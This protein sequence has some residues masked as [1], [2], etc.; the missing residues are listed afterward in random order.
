MESVLLVICPPAGSKH[1]PYG[2]IAFL[3]TAVVIAGKIPKIVP[4]IHNIGV[5]RTN[6]DVA[7]FSPSYII[8]VG[9]GNTCERRT[10]GQRDGP[11]V[12]FIAIHPLRNLLISR[13]MVH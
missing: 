11:V 3:A 9:L 12:L 10:A 4:G 6:G 8:D 7:A 5:I 13:Y 1:R 2:D